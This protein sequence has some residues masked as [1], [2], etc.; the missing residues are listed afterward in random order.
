L[1]SPKEDL[2]SPSQGNLNVTSQLFT[3]A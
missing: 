2:S 1:G 3:V